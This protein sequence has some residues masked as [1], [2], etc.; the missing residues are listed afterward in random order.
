[1]KVVVR[2]EGDMCD[3]W[4]MKRVKSMEQIRGYTTL[5]RRQGPAVGSRGL[6]HQ[7]RVCELIDGALPEKPLH[8]VRKTVMLAPTEH[9]PRRRFRRE[10]VGWGCIHRLDGAFPPRPLAGEWRRANFSLAEDAV[11][12]RGA[13]ARPRVYPACGPS[14]VRTVG[15]RC[16]LSDTVD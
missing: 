15:E 7:H 5:C 8:A 10:V 9:E 1:M 2:C 12:I 14:R 6:P 4:H 13:E 3:V 16:L 11:R